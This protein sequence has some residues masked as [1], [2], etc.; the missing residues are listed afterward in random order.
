[1]RGDGAIAP[2]K[3]AAKKR[4][5][6][7]KKAAAPIKRMAA[8]AV[9]KTLIIPDDQ[10]KKILAAFYIVGYDPRTERDMMAALRKATGKDDYEIGLM[11]DDISAQIKVAGSPF[12]PMPQIIS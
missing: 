3:K 9:P 1:V 4:A 11:Y 10:F 5:P 8:G 12:G 7:A 6:V 2:K